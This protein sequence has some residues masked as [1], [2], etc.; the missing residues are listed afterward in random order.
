MH[1]NP[2]V[3]SPK[4]SIPHPHGGHFALDPHPWNFC[5][6][7]TWLGTLWKGYFRKKK[8]AA[9]YFYAKDNFK[10]IK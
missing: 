4:M 7:S 8:V 3:K 5:N 10:K 1:G 6:F 9:L 2:V